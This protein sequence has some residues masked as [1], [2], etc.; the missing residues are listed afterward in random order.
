MSRDGPVDRIPY[1]AL[2]GVP[3]SLDV[4][5]DH[6]WTLVSGT[7]PN[8]RIFDVTRHRAE[9]I[10][11][12]GRAQ[13]AD[14]SS[15]SSGTRTRDK[16]PQAGPLTL[17]IESPGRPKLEVKGLY[18]VASQPGATVNTR[19]VLVVDRR[20]LWKRILVE[21]SYNLRRRTGE[22]RLLQGEVTPVQ[23][24]PRAPDFVYK[25][26]TLNGERPWTAREILEDVLTE[27]CGQGGYVFDD[28]PELQDAVEGLELHETGDEA[29]QRVLGF[30]PGL[31]VYAHPDG[32]AHVYNT[33]RNG[34]L[35]VATS[36]GPPL[37]GSGNWE[38]VDRS[39]VRPPRV[40]VYF[41]R[42]LE[43][44][45][46]FDA[47]EARSITRGREPRMLENVLP[48]P[49]P[50]LQ[51]FN[52]RTVAY[53]TWI[54]IEEALAAWD[55]LGDYPVSKGPLRMKHL[56][57]HAI[58]GWSF[59]HHHYTAQ[60]GLN[61]VHQDWARRINALQEHFRRTFRVLPQWVDKVRSFRAYRVAIVDQEN[62]TRA[63]SDAYFN[64]IV[65][66]GARGLIKHS[67]GA[68]L[69]YVME[70][71][72]ED[73]ADAKIAPAEV[74]VL[75]EENGIIR[76]TSRVDPGGLA[77]DIAHGTVQEIPKVKAG[78]ATVLWSSRNIHLDADWM[79][80][81]VITCAQAVPNNLGRLHEETV[82]ADEA[83]PFMPGNVKIGTC[84]GPDVE[85]LISEGVETMRY[86]WLD[87]EA[88]AIEDVFFDG[89]PP[90]EQLA[91]NPEMVRAL[92]RAQAARIYSLLL[93]RAEGSF[94]VSLR[95][96][97]VPTGSLASVTHKVSR[98]DERSVI[99]TTTLM[100]PPIVI[101]PSIMALVPESVRRVIRRMVQP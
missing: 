85:T 93:D 15:A 97:V 73:L 45:F 29:L 80:S 18:V 99:S 8:Q 91:V 54:T 40:R 16:P 11:A 62:G 65:K 88:A 79:L 78:E 101:P 49:D 86:A 46:D 5:Q 21:R 43:V 22:F 58:G 3:L 31:A 39:Y 1:V 56:R 94:S 41:G 67:S 50:Q 2:G 27:L 59:L 48:C 77:T 35:A 7:Q 98:P 30:L 92:A 28:E 17:E 57:R 83:T 6:G 55:L 25:R 74:E 100:M 37:W 26:A 24:A 89:K 38:V 10:L 53:G 70:G 71:W 64:Y 20:W 60:D 87:S 96:S 12:R 33:L 82:T 66:L 36:V 69:G 75:D 63:R 68:D 52:G 32:K 9:A 72:A 4:G 23:V 19:G 34:E 95:P 13:L 90:P 84:R 42:E 44:R 51:L 61:E 14:P 81:V 47:Q 76:V